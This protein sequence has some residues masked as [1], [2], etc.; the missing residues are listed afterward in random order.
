MPDFPSSS[1]ASGI[2]TLDKHVKD[3]MGNNFPSMITP[4]I[5]YLVIAGGGGGGGEASGGG[6]AGGYR[7]NVA[8][9]TSGG[10]A[11]AE[12]SFAIT[13]GTSYTVTVG[14]G[15]TASITFSSIPSTY[16]HLQIRIFGQTNR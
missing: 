16:K 15:G 1:S 4:A 8:G 10:G 6:G 14:S 2:W 5:E 13:P 9:A 3:K 12:A 11:S 7:T